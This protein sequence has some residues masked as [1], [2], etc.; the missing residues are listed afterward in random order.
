MIAKMDVL[1]HSVPVMVTGLIKQIHT[2][3]LC[4]CPLDSYD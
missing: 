1:S 4:N 2:L 3:V